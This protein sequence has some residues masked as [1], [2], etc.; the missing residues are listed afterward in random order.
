MNLSITRP[1]LASPRLHLVPFV[2]VLDSTSQGH[3][4]VGS[5]PLGGQCSL[6][7]F[8]VPVNMHTK[9]EASPP[10]HSIEPPW[11][12]HGNFQDTYMT[13]VFL[14]GQR[15]SPIHWRKCQPM[16]DRESFPNIR[17]ASWP[18]NQSTNSPTMIT[19]LFGYSNFG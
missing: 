10:V 6:E 12:L 11:P 16:Q 19:G 9:S 1:E 8:T 2:F 13:L 7:H 14:P 18:H 15:L 17:R 4:N 5:W 3:M